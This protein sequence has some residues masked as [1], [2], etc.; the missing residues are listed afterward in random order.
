MTPLFCLPKG[1]TKAQVCGL[2]LTLRE[3]FLLAWESFLHM[4]SSH[5]SKL[6]LANVRS[7]PREL[8]IG[9]VG[10]WVRDMEC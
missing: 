4:F 10:V 7:M 8:A 9:Y 6:T 2:S 3:S 5:L 1:S